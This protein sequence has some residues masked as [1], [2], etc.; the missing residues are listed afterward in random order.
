MHAHRIQ[1]WLTL[2]VAL[3]PQDPAASAKPAHHS[4]LV[5][6]GRTGYVYRPNSSATAAGAVL[7]LHGSGCVASDMFGLGFEAMADARGF[8]VVYPEMQTPKASEWGYLGDIPYFAALARRLR[9][10]DFGV[11]RD[12]IFICGHSAGGTMVTLLQNEMDEF[13]AAGVVEAAVGHLQNWTMSRRGKPTIVVWN[14]ADPVVKQYAPGGIEM[15]YYNLTVDTLRRGSSTAPDV[16]QQLPKSRPVTQ[17]ELLTFNEDAAA[18]PLLQV[19][20]WRSEPGRHAW[21]SPSWTNS[22]DATK[23]LIEFFFG[24]A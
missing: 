16:R 10:P 21:P 12:K 5:V 20:S 23:L 3:L 2:V 9:E 1:R 4:Q 24:Q 11:P 19:A 22:V 13:A 8:L 14:H 18:A 7:V 17:A 15:A 6:S